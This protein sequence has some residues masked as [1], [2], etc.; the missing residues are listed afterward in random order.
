MGLAVLDTCVAP[1]HMKGIEKKMI[2]NVFLQS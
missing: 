1:V 2:V